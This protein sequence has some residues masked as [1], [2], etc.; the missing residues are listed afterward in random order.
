MRDKK[1]A[2]PASLYFDEFQYLAATEA[3]RS[4]VDYLLRQCRTKNTNISVMTQSPSD[5]SGFMQN[6]SSRFIFTINPDSKSFKGEDEMEHAA[7]L[8]NISLEDAQETLPMLGNGVSVFRDVDGR[9]SK[10]KFFSLFEHWLPYLET[11]PIKRARL[12]NS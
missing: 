12:E 2:T 5:V 11:N 10:V 6:I 8:L 3:G 4:K 9:V 7:K 1:R